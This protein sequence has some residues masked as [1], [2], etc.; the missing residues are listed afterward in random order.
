M[1][2]EQNN[3]GLLSKALN[4]IEGYL[5]ERLEKG[6]KKPEAEDG[7]NIAQYED[8]EDVLYR[9]S[10]YRDG[11]YSVGAVGYQEKTVRLSF[12]LLRE[13]SKRDTVVSAIIQNYQNDVSDFAK[14]AKAKYEKGFKIVPKNE[15]KKIQ[16]IMD[17]L[18]GESEEESARKVEDANFEEEES[19]EKDS[20]RNPEEGNEEESQ[21]SNDNFNKA[22]GDQ[23]DEKPETSEES[24]E[25][26]S[27]QEGAQELQEITEDPEK[28][29]IEAV[30]EEN[31][32]ERE[33]ERVAR[34]VLTRRNMD[35][36]EKIKRLLMG[37]GDMD[38]RSFE[39]RRWN[40]EALLR[41]IVRDSLTY[42][43]YAVERIRDKQG[44]LHHWVPVDAGTIRF[45]TPALKMQR[46]Q[47]AN[48]FAY[49][50][51]YPEKELEALE[52]KDAIQL[53]DQK[54]DK[55]QYKWVQVIRGKIE[56]AFTE[57]E[58][59]VGMRNPTTD[60]YANGY[61]IPELEILMNTI[62][63]HIFTENYNR[64]YFTQGFSAK[65]I[66]HIKAALPRRKLE[67]FRIQWNHLLKGNKNTFQ[68]PIVSGMEDIQWIPLT[69]NHSDMEFSNWMNYLIKVIC[70]IY[71]I[72]P[73]E[74]G[75]GMREEGGRGGSLGGDNT[76]EKIQLSKEKG[77]KPLLTHLETFL[78]QYI[79]SEI[80]PEFEIKFVGLDDESRKEAI[81]RQK[82]EVKFKKSINEIR[83]EDDLP[84][85]D[86]C[87][88][89]ILDPQYM[90]WYVNMSADAKKSLI[91]D[92][93]MGI[94]QEPENP[95][96]SEGE[97]S[98]KKDKPEKGG[99]PPKKEES[100]E[101]KKSLVTI[102]HYYGVKED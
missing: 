75:F 80:D 22:E 67:A 96:E 94:N 15:R 92:Q 53:D 24:P 29:A 82:E 93:A 4:A 68:T 59:S 25:E 78:N 87:D 60:I 6:N 41:A 44:K 77:L 31:I 49:D 61:S 2:D 36:I 70:S 54:L 79:V 76:R 83:A 18:F 89:L 99:F 12:Q 14:P 88:K 33:K 9:K 74:I 55:D 45:A 56:R 11:S 23:P 52:Q 51:L 38:D 97:V 90:N 84:P 63:S 46:G 1:A 50:I 48:E 16:E 71:Q 35:K 65:G 3:E 20:E 91:E 21:E 101:V 34:E 81:A 64:L 17:E 40:F 27:N 102:E 86:G 19:K 95:F 13:M 5:D 42:D 47:V 72:D 32:S 100:E 10:A 73:V 85:M 37:C 43:Q 7:A 62:S 57:E 28:E 69:Q 66:L 39:D 8:S 58:L 26:V 30:E 98:S